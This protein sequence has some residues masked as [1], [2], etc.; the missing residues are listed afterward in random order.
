VRRATLVALMLLAGGPAPVRAQDPPRHYTDL[1]QL[2]AARGAPVLAYRLSVD[3]TDLSAFSVELVIRGAPDTVRLGM[4]VH[5]EYDDRFFR[6]VDAVEATGPQG[7][8]VTRQDSTRWRLVAPGGVSTVRYRI[9]LPAAQSPRSGWKPFLTPTGGLLGGPHGFMFLEDATLAPAS[10]TLDLP[11]SWRVAT[12]LEPTADPKTYF[13]SSA[14]SLIDSPI[15]AGRLRT[16]RYAE[17]GVPH[18]VAWWPAPDA[19]PFDTLALV[20]G[21]ARISHEAAGLFGRLPYREYT[22]QIQDGAVGSLEHLNSVSLGARSAGLARGLDGFFA[23]ATHEYIHGWNLMRLRPTEYGDVSA[24]AP[25]RSRGLWWAEGV[26]LYYA[27]LVLRRAGLPRLEPTRAAHLQSL[28][29]RYLSRPGN[30]RFSAESVSVVAYG[31]QPGALGDYDASTHLQGEIIGTVLD[32]MVRDATDG[33]RS[34]ADVLRLLLERFSGPRGYTSRDIERAVAEVCGCR[35][36]TFFDRYVRGPHPMEFDRY[37]ALAGL[38]TRVR[39]EAA[40]DTT[41]RPVP[42]LRV[43]AWDPPDSLGPSLLLP[44]PAG[45][46]GR[47]GLHTGDRVKAIN[48]TSVRS[49]AEFSDARNRLA[50]GDSVRIDVDGPRGRRTALLVMTGYQRPVVQVEELPGAP[51]RAVRIRRAWL[52]GE[53]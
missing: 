6:Y 51:D 41:G 33:R 12:G 48:G 21:L 27:D 52:A 9:R 30:A 29:T 31:S 4:A 28:I 8:T 47:A 19:T 13:A 7:A 22:W 35:M 3:S 16:W 2:R 18:Q 46:W 24:T 39:W 1:V 10:V 45:A 38:V 49:R 34:L 15:L 25:P 23:E 43:F 17:D 26:T 40:T 14:F 50:I 11:E 5:P 53:R 36:A 37:L 20:S 32:F 44:D 42:D